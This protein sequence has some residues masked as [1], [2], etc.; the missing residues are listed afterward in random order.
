MKKSRTRA[1][2]AGVET[3]RHLLLV[4]RLVDARTELFE[5]AVRSG[6]KVVEAMLEEDRTAPCGPRDAH[7]GARQASR[8]GTVGREVVAGGRKV[9]IRRP[10][11]RAEGHEVRLPTVQAVAEVDPWNRRVVAQL[12]VGVA[13]RRDA[14]RLEPV[15]ATLPRSAAVA[16][17]RSTL[18]PAASACSR[19]TCARRPA[20]TCHP[21]R[22]PA[23][24]STRGRGGS[25][26]SEPGGR[27]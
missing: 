9:T 2:P 11:V 24:H 18:T 19:S 5:R 23:N 6:L 10:R 21:R 26:V 27:G 1:H 16:T 13:T 3:P 8:A 14:R 17:R 4:D 22:L 20:S 15:P 7:D 12:L 25:K